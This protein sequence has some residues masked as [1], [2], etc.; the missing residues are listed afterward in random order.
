MKHAYLIMAHNNPKVLKV[1]LEML[2]DERNDIFLHIDKKSSLLAQNTFSVNQARLFIL[3]NRI[4]VFWGGYTQVQ[5]EMLLFRESNKHGPYLYYHLLSGVDLPIKS[6]EYI[7]D[8]MEKHKGKEFIGYQPKDERIKKMI[9]FR[10]GRWWLMQ[11]YFRADGNLLKWIRR[12][13]FNIIAR[14]FVRRIDMD[15]QK[16][17]TW[18]SLSEGCVCYLLESEKIIAKRFKYTFCPD[19]LFIQT[20]V[21]ANSRFYNNVY[22]PSSE[23]DSCMREIDWTRGRPYTWTSADKAILK[24]SEKL[25]ARKFSESDMEIV[26]WIKDEFASPS[27]ASNNVE[28]L[29]ERTT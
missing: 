21:C 12:T 9:K 10:V 6:Q 3:E 26:S 27:T 11:R 25:F 18:V 29:G 14:P 22:N 2:D 20:V 7:H 24:H 1:L 17:A 5:A 28:D 23:Y 19:E 16:G 13:F 4:S 15:F 8:F